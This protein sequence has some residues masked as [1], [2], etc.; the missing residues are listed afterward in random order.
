ME[1]QEIW[2]NYS[3]ELYFFILKKVQD[4]NTANDILQNT[5]LKV[6][7]NLAKL[8]AM[9]KVRAWTFQIAR[10]EIANYFNS[11]TTYAEKLNTNQSIPEREVPFTCCFDRLIEELPKI[12]KEAVEMVYIQGYK[13]KEVAQAL[14]ISLENTKAR[15]RRAKEI[16]K[17]NFRVCCNYEVNKAGKLVGEADCSTC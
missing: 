9:D 5:F 11:A 13:Q 12:Y 10:N 16:L 2:N 3:D 17:E 7:D 8:Q 1:T 15:I 4:K 6:H 14:G